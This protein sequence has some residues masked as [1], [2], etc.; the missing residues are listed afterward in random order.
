MQ[1]VRVTNFA[2]LLRAIAELRAEWIEAGCPHDIE[3]GSLLRRLNNLYMCVGT[4]A[5]DVAE[6]LDPQIISSREIA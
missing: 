6:L 2:Q 3:E 4:E 5:E 1:D